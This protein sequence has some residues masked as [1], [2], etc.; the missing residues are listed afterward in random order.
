MIKQLIWNDIKQNKLLSGATV[1]FMTLS[2]LLFSLTALLFSSLLGAIDGLMDKAVVPDYMQM[3]TGAVEVSEI[4]RF[5]ESHTEIEDWQICQFLNL[6][7]SQITLGGQSLVDS[8]QDNGLCVQG[9]RFDYL[10]DME[11]S[12]PEVLP[13][14]VYVPVCY[15]IRYDLSVGDRMEIGNYGLRIAGFL[16]DAQMNSMMASSKRFLVNTADYEA[17]KAEGEEEY[18]IEFLLSDS[19]DTNM[20]S[21]EYAM[22]GLPANGPV[23][24]RPLIR[25]INALSDGTMIFVLFLLSIV[26][27]LIAMLCIR[28]ILSLQM[29]RS[30]KE[31]GMLKALGIKN[32]EI[33]RLYFMK[34]V[35][36]SG[37]GALIGLLTACLLKEPLTK[38]LQ[39]LY[40]VSGTGFQSTAPA[41][42]A[43]LLTEGIILLSVWRFLH[44]MN[45]LSALE[46]LFSAKEMRTE[47]GQ[48]VI[49]GLVTAAC[50]L[51]VIIPQNLY[52]T[53]SDP[54]FV[55]YMGIGN[56]EIRLDVRQSE[57]LDAETEQIRS[58]LDQDMEVE[59][60]VVLRT[61]SCPAVLADGK[62]INLMVET[63]DHN[64]FPVSCAEGT[65]PQDQ[66]EIALSV[67]NAEELGLTIGDTLWLIPEEQRIEYTVC[68]IY[69]DITNGG[70]TAKVYHADMHRPLA[71]SVL[72]VSLKESVDKEQW[73]KQ[74]R[75]MGADV[76]DIADYVK[77]T[78]G[79]TLE[80]L[81][82][83]SGVSIISSMLVVGVVVM[84][85]MR[86]IVEKNRY[87]VSLQKALGFTGREI[88]WNYF[89]K[90]FFPVIAGIVCGLFAGNLFGESLC[91]I[92][93][94]SFGA[95]GFRFIVAWGRIL[96]GIPAAVLVPAVLALFAG[97]AEIRQVKAYEC[98][99]G[100]E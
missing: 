74:Y 77:D 43:M 6:D 38:Q 41:V 8:T 63:G 44:R 11:N 59:Q 3:H 12:L 30:R 76:T 33:G 61:S 100:R 81:R 19:I 52:S 75:K 79:E 25:M 24:T 35:F 67:I 20:L 92:I 68:G 99:A 40:G 5:A 49:I 45:K 88:K 65:L 84:L 73:M 46:A 60:Y 39:E 57:R 27:L 28:F 17:I 26:T 70:K 62:T 37:C 66:T 50:T 29:E 15:Q 4:S 48:Y 22:E 89:R 16:R 78:Y 87:T 2:C 83:A 97:S 98:C 21:M 95:E 18:L 94:K 72:Y 80:R 47:S 85:F 51:L 10:L 14:E 13:G 32:T 1:F 36:F 93:L 34:Y 31:V 7:N 23:I 64:I 55:T 82:L 54:G 58:A 96:T 56:G 71:W 42:L 90:G 69:S 86:L 53:V 91:G 9:N